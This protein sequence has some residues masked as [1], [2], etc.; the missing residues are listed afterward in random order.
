MIQRIR[1]V[2]LGC[3]A[4]CGPVHLADRTPAGSCVAILNWTGHREWTQANVDQLGRDLPFWPRATALGEHPFLDKD[5][6]EFLYSV[7]GYDPTLHH[8]FTS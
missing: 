4:S 7:D 2:N 6:K 8:W 5:Y 3:P 1:R